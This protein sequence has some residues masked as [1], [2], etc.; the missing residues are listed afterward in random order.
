[1]KHLQVETRKMN[2]GIEL[3]FQ[4]E[5]L[6]EDAKDFMVEVPG[7]TYIKRY[8]ARNTHGR[9]KLLSDQER[10]ALL[11]EEIRTVFTDQHMSNRVIAV[12]DQVHARPKTRCEKLCRLMKSAIPESLRRR[13]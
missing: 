8:H 9:W 3:V 6:F 13:R 5:L 1:M 4:G 10:K 2:D 11:I 12:L 7:A